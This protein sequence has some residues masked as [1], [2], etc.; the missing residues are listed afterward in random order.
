LNRI[1]ITYAFVD[2]LNSFY[3]FIDKIRIYCCFKK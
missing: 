3:Y 1:E 2:H